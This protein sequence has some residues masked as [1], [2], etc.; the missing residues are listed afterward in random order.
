MVSQSACRTPWEHSVPNRMLP[1]YDEDVEK[2][3]PLLMLSG[4]LACADAHRDMHAVRTE[5]APHSACC[6]CRSLPPWA[7]NDAF[8]ELLMPVVHAWEP[9]NNN[10]NKETMPMNAQTL[11][12][13]RQIR[14]EPQLLDRFM[15][16]D[17]SDALV[18]EACAVAQERG[19]AVSDADVRAGVADLP[20]LMGA[21]AGDEL[22]DFELEFVSAGAPMNSNTGGVNR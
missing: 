18:Q 1:H 3:Q 9:A 13:Y 21:V 12:L 2:R 20:A 11:E 16:L 6:R 5:L 14:N 10:D 7:S 4:K 15:T 17:S 22:L 8:V 19:I